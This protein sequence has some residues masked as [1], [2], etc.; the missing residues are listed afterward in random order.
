MNINDIVQIL[1][2]VM[3]VSFG[4]SWPISIMKILK[5][6]SV[7]GKSPVFTAVIMFGYA[8]GILAKVL[9]KSYDDLSF[10]FY[11]L[12]LIMSSVDMGLYIYFFC[13]EKKNEKSNNK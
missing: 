6:K 7:K 8:A 2:V 12:N 9:D 10:P 11:C 1:E 13:K 3:L 5:V 4:A